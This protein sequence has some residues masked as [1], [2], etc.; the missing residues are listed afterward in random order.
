MRMWFNN[1]NWLTDTHVCSWYGVTCN[2]GRSV[3][4]LTLRGNGLQLQPEFAEVDVVELLSGLTFLK[5][6]SRRH[7]YFGV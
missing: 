5:V 1:E 7:Q 4:K 3:I 2:S 6:R